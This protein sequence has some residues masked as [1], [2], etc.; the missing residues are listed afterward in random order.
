[1]VDSSS[2]LGQRSESV[3]T[4][5]LNRKC[6]ILNAN[7]LPMAT[8]PLS[9]VTGQEAIKA[10]IRGRATVVEE[11]DD[12]CHSPSIEM[13]VPRVLVLNEYAPV[14]AAPKFCRKSVI[15]RDKFRCQYCG[16]Q[17]ASEDLT[18]DHVIPRSSGGATVWE[19]ILMA[20]VE[21]NT[22]K[23]SQ[24]ANWSG[25]KGSGLRPL[26]MPRQPTT[27]EL[28]RAGLEF[29]DPVVKEDFK[30]YLYWSSSLQA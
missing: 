24:P 6:L 30:S 16:N 12:V 11:W 9:L 17:F 20:C 27:M 28:L 19:N 26:K 2:T 25:K 15:L 18:F 22:R 5:A 23:R 10:V 29:I 8:W 4:F 21:C 3:M 13:R 1:M 14:N 7:Y